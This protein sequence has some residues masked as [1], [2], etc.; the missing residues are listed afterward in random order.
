M[1]VVVSSIVRSGHVQ[2]II[3]I[4]ASVLLS[5]TVALWLRSQKFR[6][7]DIVSASFPFP[8]PFSPSFISV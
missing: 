3:S 4:N 2:I 6:L 5:V 8:P 7:Y 1:P